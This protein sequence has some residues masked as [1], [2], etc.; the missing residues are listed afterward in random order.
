MSAAKA[1]GAELRKQ[2]SLAKTLHACTPCFDK[3]L[4]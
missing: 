1:P 3:L 2:A 4:P